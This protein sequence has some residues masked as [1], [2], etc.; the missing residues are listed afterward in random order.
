MRSSCDDNLAAYTIG[1]LA[2]GAF[3]GGGTWSFFIQ[4]QRIDGS[5]N[6]ADPIMAF[7]HGSNDLI[8]SGQDN[9]IIRT[10]TEAGHPVTGAVDIHKLTV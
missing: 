10:G 1:R 8:H 6:I 7:F 3:S 4:A 9:D 5:R 2:F